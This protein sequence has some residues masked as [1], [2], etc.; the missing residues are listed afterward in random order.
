MLLWVTV[1]KSTAHDSRLFPCYLDL[2]TSKVQT[3]TCCL[4]D[5]GFYRLLLFSTEEPQRCNQVITV[6]LTPQQC[7]MLQESANIG[8]TSQ[9]IAQAIVS[10]RI[11]KL[12][13]EQ[14]KSQVSNKLDSLDRFNYPTQAELAHSIS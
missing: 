13:F 7:Q 12:K 6:T 1:L 10:R 8:Q 9:P 4:A 5:K 14:L 11:L 2:K 3:I